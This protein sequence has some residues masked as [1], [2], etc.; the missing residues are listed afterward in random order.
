[1]LYVTYIH[2]YIYHHFYFSHYFGTGK[3]HHI[4]FLHLMIYTKTFIAG[5]YFS[6]FSERETETE[7]PTVTFARSTELISGRL[8][9]TQA[10]IKL[11]LLFTELHV[12]NAIAIY[13][14]HKCLLE[15]HFSFGMWMLS[16]RVCQNN[17]LKLMLE[18]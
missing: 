4:C 12:F 10:Y 2:I 1:M 17:L 5:F 11:I 8:N 13:T 15:S 9:L 6:Y 14:K 16:F 18:Y 7:K 3:I